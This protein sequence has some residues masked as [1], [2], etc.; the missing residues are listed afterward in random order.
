MPPPNAG[1]EHAAAPHGNA[2]ALANVVNG[3]G[4][5]E[6]AQA[7]D[8]D[9]DNAAGAQLDGSFGIAGLAN[10]FV[11]ANRGF[12]LALQLRM[13]K[14]VVIPERLLDHEQ[15]EFVEFA[16]VAKIAGGVR[17]IR[18]AAQEDVRPALADLREYLQVPS[19]FYFY[20]DSLIA[21]F[22][23]SCNFLEQLLVRVL[24]SNGN[25]AV[26]FA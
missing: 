13:L 24:N 1:F 20:F 21:S 26:D 9:I 17:G 16:K 14:D 15:L 8:F 12:Q 19:R 4:F 25:S 2:V 22:E 5:A 10:R 23:L 7:P 11:E 3:D 18:V 6:S